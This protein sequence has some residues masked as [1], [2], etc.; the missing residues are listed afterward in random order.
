MPIPPETN[1]LRTAARSYLRAIDQLT[2]AAHMNPNLTITPFAGQVPQTWS[3]NLG[4]SLRDLY[5][6][7]IDRHRLWEER[8]SGSWSRT[9]CGS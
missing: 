5:A 8:R 9:G 6:L 2:H 7:I 3:Q 4:V 1:A